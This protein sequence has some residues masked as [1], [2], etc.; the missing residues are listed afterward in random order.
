MKTRKVKNTST[1]TGRVSSMQIGRW[2]EETKTIS[3]VHLPQF[4]LVTYREDTG[5][6]TSAKF[7]NI[8]DATTESGLAEFDN[9]IDSLKF[10]IEYRSKLEF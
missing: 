8:S 9:E 6:V 2:N 1:E 4:E 10:A 3:V 5:D 7:V